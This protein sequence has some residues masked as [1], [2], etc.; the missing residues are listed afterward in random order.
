MNVSGAVPPAMT[1]MPYVP[2]PRKVRGTLRSTLS[3]SPVM[4]A[5]YQVSP[6]RRANTACVRGSP[7]RRRVSSQVDGTSLMKSRTYG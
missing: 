3:L 7:D 4:A 6:L 1:S 5:T 2:E